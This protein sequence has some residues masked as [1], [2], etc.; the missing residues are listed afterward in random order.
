MLP[1]RRV[2]VDPGTPGG[3]IYAG[4]TDVAIGV[5]EGNPLP[6]FTTTPGTT[7]YRI[8]VINIK[9]EDGVSIEA[10]DTI[11]QGASCYGSA[12]GRVSNSSAYG[13]V[14]VGTNFAVGVVAGA[15]TDVWIAP[16]GS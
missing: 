12:N 10:N 13:A 11:A 2:K 5:T 15:N 6:G 7:T 4:A 3:V 16:T 8:A 9:T 14:L 1:N